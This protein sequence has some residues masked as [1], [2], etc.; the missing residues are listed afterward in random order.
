MSNSFILPLDRN[1]TGAII[2]GQS[3]P[4]SDGNEEILCVPQNSSITG[5]SP[6]DRLVL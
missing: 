5:A 6:S 4:G 1:L 3:V 2:P